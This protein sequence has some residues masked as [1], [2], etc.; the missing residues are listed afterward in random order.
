[1]LVGGLC[2]AESPRWH[3][4][5]L[6]ASD[7]YDRRVLA[8]DAAGGVETVA[9]VPD[10]PS[11]LGWLPDGRLLVVSMLAQ[12]VLRREPDGSLVEHADLAGLA[13]GACNDLIVDAAGVAWVGC[14][15]FDLFGGAKPQPAPLI[16]VSP[17]GSA[18]VVATDL[19]FPNGMALFGDDLV[20]AET[21]GE[22][23]SAFA[24]REN[25][26]LGERRTWARTP[27][28]RPDGICQDAE[29]A[30]WVADCTG[31]R[32]VRVAEGGTV[33]EEIRGADGAFACCL[34]GPDGRTLFICCAAGAAP[35]VAAARTGSIVAFEVEV[36]AM[37]M[38]A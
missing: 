37:E 25:G 33:L 38:C 22:R 7:F 15:G 5:R 24:R 26:T 2:F 30:I 34:G 18:R 4:G 32:C 36:P 19:R 6:W 35:Q 16:C 8:I 12:R 9:V 20:I 17:D 1:V 31:G 3:D 29:A 13:R 11:G 21:M 27:G 28:I 23:L 14:F 10:Q